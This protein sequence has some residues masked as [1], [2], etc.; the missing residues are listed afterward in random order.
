M[1]ILAAALAVLALPAP[2]AARPVSYPGG[3]TVIGEMEPMMGSALIH[4]TPNRH[5]SVGAR[6]VHMRDTAFNLLGPQATWLVKRWNMPGA[7]ANFYLTGMGGAGWADRQS[8]RPGGFVEAQGDW[9]NRRLMLMASTRLTHA[10]PMGTTNMQMARIGWAPYA[11]DYGDVHLWLFGQLMRESAARDEIQ[12]A[13]V[14]RIF[15]RTLLV[16]A[17]VTDRGG[18]I[19]NSTIRF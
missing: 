19:L 8:A 9:E 6:Y 10:E 15:Y 1:R 18:L 14:G 4:Y 16:E 5:Y 3:L 17:G 12:P 2:V 11:G 13:L 7:Q